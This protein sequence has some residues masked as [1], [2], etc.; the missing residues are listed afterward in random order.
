MKLAEKILSNMS[1][2]QVSVSRYF[3][4]SSSLQA[5]SEIVEVIGDKRFAK[6]LENNADKLEKMSKK[7]KVDQ[8]EF[9]KIMKEVD[10][11]GTFK[12]LQKVIGDYDKSGKGMRYGRQKVNLADALKNFIAV[13]QKAKKE[14]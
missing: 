13:A 12:R 8:S 2:S 7:A 9:S 11:S 10:L 3:D 6:E 1:E 14:E 4:V 5:L